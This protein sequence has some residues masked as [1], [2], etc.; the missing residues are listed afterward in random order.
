MAKLIIKQNAFNKIYHLLSLDMKF[1]I[2]RKWLLLFTILF[3][4]T[5]CSKE[6]TGSQSKS[7][8]ACF[9]YSPSEY[10]IV[11][12]TV[13]YTNYAPDT[14]HFANCS[15]NA[16]SYFWDFG[17]N[18][19]STDANPTH[20]YTI[21]ATEYVGGPFNVR[22]TAKGIIDSDLNIQQISVQTLNC[23]TIKII[24]HTNGGL[25]VWLN[26]NRSTHDL[27]SDSVF[28]FSGLPA[29]VYTIE[30]QGNCCNL[31]QDTLNVSCGTI[32]ETYP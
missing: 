22:L 2:I 18:S 20:I 14:I 28:S 13:Q 25:D 9:T 16:T 12:D 27:T 19:T 31:K 3:F 21:A 11:A 17:D 7:T 1:K 6:I 15:T 32:I 24:N 26:G 4:L 8:T 10:K 29:G 5:K 30:I 23:G